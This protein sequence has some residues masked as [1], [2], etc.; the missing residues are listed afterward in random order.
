MSRSQ[1]QRRKKGRR[2]K[3]NSCSMCEKGPHGDCGY[4]LDHL[5]DELR[6]IRITQKGRQCRLPKIEGLDICKVHLQNAKRGQGAGS[7][8][9]VYV[10]DTAFKDGEKGIYKIGRSVKP[11]ARAYALEAG[12]PCG[13]MLFAGFMGNQARSIER[14]LHRRYHDDWVK[15][16]LFALTEFQLSVIRSRLKTASSGWYE[17]SPPVLGIWPEQAVVFGWS[18]GG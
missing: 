4:C 10:Y 11:K 14:E 15:R 2:G 17:P 8:G 16:E 3:N 12:N 7:Y 6:C 1:R 13:K 5:P 18:K 9:W